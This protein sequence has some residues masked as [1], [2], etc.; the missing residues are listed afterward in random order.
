MACTIAVFVALGMAGLRAADRAR[1][2]DLAGMGDTASWAAAVTGEKRG[3]TRGDCE[4]A[5]KL[6]DLGPV[7]EAFADGRVSKSQASA[8]AGAHGASDAEQTGLLAAAAALSLNELERH[9]ERFNLDRDRPSDPIVPTVVITPTKTGIKADVTLDALGGE[10]LTTA[11]D[12]AAQQLSFD[13]G[14]GRA[15]RRAAGLVAISRYF[16][17]HHT[18]VTHRLGRPH[19]VANIPLAVLAGETGSAVLGSGAVID[20]ATAR[21]LA[22]DA[23][24]SRLITG[25]A[26]EPLDVGR[27]TRSIPTAIARQ[28][29]IDDQHCRHP[30]CQAPTW[31]CEAH[32]VIWWEGP[33]NGETKL[34]NLVLLCWQHHHLIH[35]DPAGA[36][37]S[38]PPPAASTSPTATATSAPPLRQDDNEPSRT[39][40]RPTHAHPPPTNPSTWSR[41]RAPDDDTRPD[42][43]CGPAEGRCIGSAHAE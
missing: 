43:G 35:N 39:P 9:V 13:K 4:L 41:S 31:A 28:L 37:C 5:G 18:N 17:E 33:G 1:V 27:A 19:V 42:G 7:A 14:T 25:A 15:E 21:Q 12:A 36:S 32:H 30:G 24:I 26:S 38:T 2:G 40:P 16:L 6:A 3:K 22:C 10:M 23:S 34:T 20:A 8:L 29:I 11:L